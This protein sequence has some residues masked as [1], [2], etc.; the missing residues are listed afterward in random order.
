MGLSESK[1]E[2]LTTEERQYREQTKVTMVKQRQEQIDHLQKDMIESVRSN[3]STAIIRPKDVV[4]MIK[5]TETAKNQLDRG[6]GVLTKPDLI[7]I[8]IALQPEMR[9]DIARLESVTVSDLNSMIRSIIY[10]PSRVMHQAQLK[11]PGQKEP[12]KALTFF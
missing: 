10:D 7:A 2:R 12:V 6:G 4:A 5:V 8:I 9:N 11:E 1:P 3:Q